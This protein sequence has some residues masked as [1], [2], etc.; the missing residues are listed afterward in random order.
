MVNRKNKNAPKG[1]RVVRT[2][3]LLKMGSGT[4]SGFV[5]PGPVGMACRRVSLGVGLPRGL[6]LLSKFEV[7]R[8]C[9]T[10]VA[11]SIVAEG[12]WVDPRCRHCCRPPQTRGEEG[13]GMGPRELFLH[14]LQEGGLSR[15]SIFCC[16]CCCWYEGPLTRRVQASILLNEGPLTQRVQASILS[17]ERTRSN[18]T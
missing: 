16:C 13:Q 8:P 14:G 4:P 7:S 1:I 15:V 12:G 6:V 17:Y 9:T 11:P 2:R 3:M 5:W 18:G 10:V